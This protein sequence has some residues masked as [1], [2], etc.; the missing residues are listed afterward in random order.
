MIEPGS[1]V[2]TLIDT[3]WM[4]SFQIRVVTCRPRIYSI[5]MLPRIPRGLRWRWTCLH[6]TIGGTIKRSSL[7]WARPSELS[8]SF[9]IQSINSSLFS[10]TRLN[11]TYGV[12]L[13]EFVQILRDQKSSKVVHRRKAGYLGRNQLSWDLG[14][15]PDNYDLPLDSDV[16][17]ERIDKLNKEF[18]LVINILKIYPSKIWN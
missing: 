2:D 5:A 18:E 14:I 13:K 1:N 10:Y 4:S 7:S 8:P 16:I 12:N 6:Y 3:D 15:D 11:V 9:V 17:R